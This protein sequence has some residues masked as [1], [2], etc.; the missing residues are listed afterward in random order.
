LKSQKKTENKSRIPLEKKERGNVHKE[1]LV[2][3][4][5]AVTIDITKIAFGKI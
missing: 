2:T 5:F 4:V 3:Y 1:F